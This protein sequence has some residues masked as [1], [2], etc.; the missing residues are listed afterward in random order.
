[1]AAPPRSGPV[2]SQRFPAKI[3]LI[4]LSWPPRSKIAPPPPPSYCWP[5]EFPSLNVMFWMMSLGVAWSWQCD[6]VQTWAGSQVSRYR[7][8]RAPPPLSVT[9]PPPSST[10]SE[11]VL[12]TLAVACI[13]IVT[14][15]APQSKVITPPLA[16]AATTAPDVQLAAV[17]LPIT[18][19]GWAVFTGRA[20]A[21]MGAPPAGFPAR[22]RCRT[23]AACLR[24]LVKAADPA[25]P[26]PAAPAGE[27]AAGWPDDAARDATGTPA[28]PHA[29]SRAPE[30]ARAST[31]APV[32]IRT[33]PH[34]ATGNGRII[35]FPANHP[36]ARLPACRQAGDRQESADH[37]IHLVRDFE[38]DEV[39]GPD[40]LADRDRRAGLAEIGSG[41]GRT[42]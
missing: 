30:P 23:A 9:F 42:G 5:V 26:A 2:G 35:A 25:S 29:A 13:M 24:L 8:R 3:E 28:V 40:R 34:A 15:L 41:V 6:V 38:L 10:T 11:L 16:T 20:A 32:T 12:R 39:T 22:G 17:P 7:M 36:L 21:G 18:W 1:M 31:P 37:G 4:T 27:A 14:G 33:R 19:S